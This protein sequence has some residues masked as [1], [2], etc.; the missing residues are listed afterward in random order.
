[1]MD[2]Y[3]NKIINQE[4]NQNSGKIKEILIEFINKTLDK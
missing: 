1:M 3:R 4:F 2:W